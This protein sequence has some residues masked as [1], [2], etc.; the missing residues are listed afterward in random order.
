MIDSG[1]LTAWYDFQAPLYHFWRDDYAHP[2]VSTVAGLLDRDL[3]LRVLDAGCGSGQFAIGVALSRKELT[4][5]GVD[6]SPGLL[7]IARQQATKRTL[8]NVSFSQGDVQ[9]LGYRDQECAAV[10]AAGLFPNL[11]EPRRALLEFFRVLPGGGQLIVVEFDRTAMRAGTRAFFRLMIGGYRL[12]SAV[13]PRF[14]FA[15]E[16]NIELSTIDEERFDAALRAAGFT[17]EA[18]LRGHDHLVFSCRKPRPS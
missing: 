15:D 2:L 17:V 10:I 7:K 3:P 8:A 6:C 18:T 12:F 5:E 11:N 14:R 9:A 1:K 13:F 4:L 16:W